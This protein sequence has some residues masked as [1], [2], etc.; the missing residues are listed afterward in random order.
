MENEKAIQIIKN[1]IHDDIAV[2]GNKPKLRN[3]ALDLAIKALEARPQGEW[4]Q[5]EDTPA[6]VYYCCSNCGMEDIPI[7]PFCPWC[8]AKMK[9]STE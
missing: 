8:G 1:M 2:Y 9:G 3:E 5:K 6:S 4:I 7:T